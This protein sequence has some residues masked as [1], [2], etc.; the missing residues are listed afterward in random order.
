MTVGRCPH[1]P[2]RQGNLKSDNGSRG[3]LAPPASICLGRGST[4]IPLLTELEARGV[5][6]EWPQ[7]LIEATE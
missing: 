7:P 2:K 5:K 4:K 1:E 6:M 3:T